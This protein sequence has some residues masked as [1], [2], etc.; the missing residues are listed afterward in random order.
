[1]ISM[2]FL[3]PFL[4]KAL[5]GENSLDRSSMAFRF[6]IDAKQFVGVSKCF[7]AC[8]RKA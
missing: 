7:A 6:P 2:P 1:M 5:K 8:R 4:K 3:L